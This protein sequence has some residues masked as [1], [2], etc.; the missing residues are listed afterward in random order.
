MTKNSKSRK[1]ST[2]KV[3]IETMLSVN[4]KEMNLE[5][6]GSEKDSKRMSTS[7]LGRNELSFKQI[8]KEGSMKQKE[9]LRLIQIRLKLTTQSRRTLSP[10]KARNQTET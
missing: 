9:Q 8:F 7:C 4:S 2:S 1:R 10:S 3:V 5:S 6:R